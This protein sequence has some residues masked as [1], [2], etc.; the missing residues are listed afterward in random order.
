MQVCKPKDSEGN[1]F[2]PALSTSSVQTTTIYSFVEAMWANSSSIN[3]LSKLSL[4]NKSTRQKNLVFPAQKI[5][6]LEIFDIQ[7]N[8][9]VT[10][11]KVI[12]DL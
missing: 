6:N 8:R 3:I 11:I 12:N 2:W 1:D 4:I 10:S 9:A 7:A 5:A